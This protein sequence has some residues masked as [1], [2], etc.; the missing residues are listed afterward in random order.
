MMDN[1]Y[2]I[3]SQQE[4]VRKKRKKKEDSVAML[5]ECT[6]PG[7]FSDLLLL[8]GGRKRKKIQVQ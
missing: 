4:G 2:F 8:G 1:I 6:M 3:N 5:S 7:L